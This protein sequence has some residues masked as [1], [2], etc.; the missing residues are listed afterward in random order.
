MNQ[1]K[2]KDEEQNAIII[3]KYANRRLYNTDTSSYITLEDLKDLVKQDTP[4]L[5]QDAKTDE[6]LTRQVLTQIIFEQ[7]AKGHNMLPVNF[8]RSL[9]SFYDTNAMTAMPQFLE[10]SM[11][12]FLQNQG[13]IMENFTPKDVTPNPTDAFTEMQQQSAEMFQNAFNMFNPF[14]P[15]NDKK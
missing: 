11:S 7:E 10:Q 9:I 14:A 3:K 15:G 12:V 6:D 13:K 5:V 2:Q 4:F 8:L 1:A